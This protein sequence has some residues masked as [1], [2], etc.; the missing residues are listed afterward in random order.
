M[1]VRYALRPF[2]G[3]RAQATS[4]STVADSPSRRTTN[5][6]TA[7][8]VLSSGTPIT[9]TF[10]IFGFRYMASSISFGYTLKPETRIISFSR[11]TI[12]K[13]PSGSIT[14]TSPVW[15]HPLRITSAVSSGR[16]Q[17][18][19]ITCGPRTHSSPRSPGATVLSASSRST[20]LQSVSGIG[21]PIDPD[22]GASKGFACVTGEHSVSP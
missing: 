22:R 5:A 20:I 7:S 16:F 15:N 2:A 17:Y 1:G 4:S 12:L 21:R 13:Y 3:S 18:P 14:A 8:P 11:S 10:A 6:F 19:S 9:A